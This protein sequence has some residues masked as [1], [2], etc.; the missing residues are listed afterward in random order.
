M[1]WHRVI[2]KHSAEAP[3]SAQG[4]MIPFMK[5]YNEAGAPEGVSV[6]ISRDDGGDRTYYFSSTASVLAKDL[7]HTFE[8]TRCF[9]AP[10]LESFRKIRL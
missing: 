5:Q 8:A 1:P 3:L 6:Y 9:A 4:L 7:L 2:L 10:N